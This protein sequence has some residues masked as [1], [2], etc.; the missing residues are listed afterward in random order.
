MVKYLSAYFIV[1]VHHAQVERL[2]NDKNKP[3]SI[4]SPCP[5]T[6]LVF[7]QDERYVEPSIPP[8]APDYLIRDQVVIGFDDVTPYLIRFRGTFLIPNH[9]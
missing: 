3:K 9:N 1:I 4:I 2:G 8:H 7:F 5:S 6:K